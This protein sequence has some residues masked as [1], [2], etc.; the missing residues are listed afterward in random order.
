MIYKASE[1]N[2]LLT[3]LTLTSTDGKIEFIGT[4]KQWAKGQPDCELCQGEGFYNE[5]DGPDDFQTIKCHCKDQ[6]FTGCS[7]ED[8]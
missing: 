2:R 3:N 7:N 4:D 1:L 6:D 5:A 8:R